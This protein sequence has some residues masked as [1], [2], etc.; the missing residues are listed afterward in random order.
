MRRASARGARRAKAA[1]AWLTER[2]AHAHAPLPHSLEKQLAF[3]TALLLE[4]GGRAP[5]ASAA[6]LLE[7]LLAA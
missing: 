5:S 7:Q 6:Q 1:R 2:R 3:S 4:W